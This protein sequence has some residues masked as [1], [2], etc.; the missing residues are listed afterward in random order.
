MKDLLFLKFSLRLRDASVMM[1]YGT[2]CKNR[3]IIDIYCQAKPIR[4]NKRLFLRIAKQKI[5]V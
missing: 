5:K 1:D 3:H 4:T 2:E